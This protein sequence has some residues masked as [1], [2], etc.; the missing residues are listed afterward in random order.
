MDPTKVDVVV[1]QGFLNTD[2]TQIA[3]GSNIVSKDFECY[4]FRHETSSLGSRYNQQYTESR[5]IQLSFELSVRG[6]L[7]SCFVRS[8]ELRPS[9]WRQRSAPPSIS[10]S[11]F[12]LWASWRSAASCAGVSGLA[13][14]QPLEALT[15]I[16]LSS[17]RRV[18]ARR[19]ELTA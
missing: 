3:P 5:H 12:S 15:F 11:L 19:R 6:A 18:A 9:V 8:V 13:S 4:R 10:R 16:S 7:R 2:R 1:L 14:W 17:L